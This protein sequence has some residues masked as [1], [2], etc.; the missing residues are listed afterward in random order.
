MTATPVQTKTAQRRPLRFE[1]FEQMWAEVQRIAA[2]ERDGRL[3]RTGNWTPGQTLGHLAT[4]ANFPY[5]G[6]PPTLRPPWLIKVILKTRKAKY[7]SGSLPA[8]VRIPKVDGGT[9]GTE[10]MS[11]DEGVARL[12]KA[13]A[14]LLAGPPKIDN[15]IF[16]PLTHDEWKAINLRHA[17]LHLG[18]LHPE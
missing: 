18:F 3:R 13:W 1:S 8:G 11:L 10:D 9:V 4:W 15:P 6:Y 17:E 7:L 5:D 12:Q 14:R 16:G 2:A